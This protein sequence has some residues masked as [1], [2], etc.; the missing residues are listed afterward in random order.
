MSLFFWWV[1]CEIQHHHEDRKAQETK[2]TGK[3]QITRSHAPVGSTFSS[4]ICLT[5]QECKQ[6]SYHFLSYSLF[7]WGCQAIP[8]S[9]FQISIGFSDSDDRQSFRRLFFWLIQTFSS[10]LATL[11]ASKSNHLVKSEFCSHKL[12]NMIKSEPLMKKSENQ[13][14]QS[15]KVKRLH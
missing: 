8:T 6:Y 5:H 10:E 3:L 14:S 4:E 2:T 11:A 7:C 1:V 9:S 12:S 15:M 13:T